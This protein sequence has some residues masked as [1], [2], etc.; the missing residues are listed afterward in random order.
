MSLERAYCLSWGYLGDDIEQWVSCH[1]YHLVGAPSEVKAG[2][3]KKETMIDKIGID[4]LY[5]LSQ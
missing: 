1:D 3:I 2:A 5:P 4:T